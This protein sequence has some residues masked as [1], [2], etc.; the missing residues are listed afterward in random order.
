MANETHIG[1]GLPD[2][3]TRLRG[4]ITGDM[5]ADFEKLETYLVNAG[6]T[7][8]DAAQWLEDVVKDRRKGV[9]AHAKLLKALFESLADALDD[10]GRLMSGVDGVGASGLSAIEEWLSTSDPISLPPVEHSYV[11][12]RNSYDT[13]DR[14]GDEPRLA[15]EVDASGNHVT[16]DDG[17]VIDL[18]DKKDAPAPNLYDQY[19][20]L[21]GQQGPPGSKPSKPGQPVPPDFMFV[22]DGY[23]VK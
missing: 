23:V 3:V 5:I 11:D 8:M 13:G 14:G 19:R 15:F 2:L 22:S 21:P 9:I 10:A 20:H 1:A 6:P 18:P 7:G 16:H 17:V 12:G 4:L